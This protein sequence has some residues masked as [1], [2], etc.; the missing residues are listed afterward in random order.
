MGCT[1]EGTTSKYV[2]SARGFL[3]GE[4]LPF[5]EANA[6][7]QDLMRAN[8]LALAR[9][10]LQ[11]MRLEPDR[12][13]GGIPDDQKVR[14]KLCCQE[15]LLTSK[16]IELNAALRHDLSLQAARRSLRARQ[17][18]TGRRQ[19][20]ARYCRWYLQAKVERS[21][22]VRRLETRRRVLSAWREG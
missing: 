14:D 12:I 5:P 19:R 1:H 4:D 18:E 6:L 13:V 11:R 16:D 8:E 15:A 7:W 21:R 10:V 22:P 3:G 17:S 9:M 20:N 2:E